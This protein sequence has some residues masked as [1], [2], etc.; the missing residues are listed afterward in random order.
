V[1]DHPFKGEIFGVGIALKR[2]RI[3]SQEISFLRDAAASE[4]AGVRNYELR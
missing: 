1:G 3:D 2:L 4:K